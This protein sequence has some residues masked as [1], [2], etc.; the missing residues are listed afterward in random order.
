M[1]VRLMG[2]TLSEENV[3]YNRID[4]ESADIAI[5]NIDAERRSYRS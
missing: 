1:A 4:K 3:S 2:S 5:K